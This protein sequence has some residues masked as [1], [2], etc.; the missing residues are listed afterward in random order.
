MRFKLTSSRVRPAAQVSPLRIKAP[1]KLF[2]GRREIVPLFARVTA[3]CGDYA[4]SNE[5]LHDN[6]KYF[7]GLMYFLV[8]ESIFNIIFLF[9]GFR[10]PFF[11]FKEC[12][13]GSS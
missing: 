5:W 1:V 11:F 2:G 8:I 4:L 9:T 10:R 13:F 6:R 7:D 3:F 12:N